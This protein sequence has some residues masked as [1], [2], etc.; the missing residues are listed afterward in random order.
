MKSKI[1]WQKI[2]VEFRAGQLS[3]REI[4]RQ[5][6]IADASIREVAKKR[7]WLRDVSEQVRQATRAKVNASHLAPRSTSHLAPDYITTEEDVIEAASNRGV[8]AVETM[9]ARAERLGKAT[10]ETLTILLTEEAPSKER[11]AALRSLAETASKVQSMI[12][13]SLSLDEPESQQLPSV[14]TCLRHFDG[15]RLVSMAQRQ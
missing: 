4:A 3:I 10:D 6:G 12:R 1:D 8:M 11:A 9:V 15:C 5:H 14:P 13:Q 7:G 2:E